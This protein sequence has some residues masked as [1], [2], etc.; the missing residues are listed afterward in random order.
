MNYIFSGSIID[1]VWQD[2]LDRL[3]LY[4]LTRRFQSPMSA[5]PSDHFNF[6]V[7][8]PKFRSVRRLPTVSV[9]HG[10]PHRLQ[11]RLLALSDRTPA[12]AISEY[13]TA[14]G[15][16]ATFRRDSKA[17]RSTANRLLALA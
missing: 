10:N 6:D 5:Y 15:L 11:E 13:P 4:W 8:R 7:F 1:C 9:P 12:P 2:G 3:L 14:M 16:W 17:C